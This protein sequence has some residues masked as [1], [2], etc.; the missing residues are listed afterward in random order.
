MSDLILLPLA[1]MAG[2]VSFI[3]PC[4][5]AMI[6]IFISYLL[7]NKDQGWL[8]G[9]L[10]GCAYTLG[11]A[12]T[13]SFFN[14]VLQLFPEAI[15]YLPVFRIGAGLLVMTLAIGLLVG[16]DFGTSKL[17]KSELLEHLSKKF[18]LLG[19]GLFGIISGLAWIPCLTPVLA[20]ILTMISLNQDFLSGYL[21]L[22]IYA[23][24]LGSPYIVIS[25][26]GIQIKS[27]TLAQ[28]V[29]YGIWIQRGLA[30]LLLGFG[31]VILLDGVNLYQIYQ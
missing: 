22:F 16:Y 17:S 11:L 12:I 26:L 19:F 9:I 4:H 3:G 14:F 8:N 15:F 10:I 27:T 30:I 5:L 7:A 2:I 28:W 18:N 24:G 25:T 6:P 20:T 31:L 21:L 29:K 13:F 1:Y 23:L